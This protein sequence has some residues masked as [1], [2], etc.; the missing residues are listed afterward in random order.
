M[1]PRQPILLPGSLYSIPPRHELSHLIAGLRERDQG[2][3]RV[4]V[5]STTVRDDGIFVKR[6]EILGNGG[7]ERL[8]NALLVQERLRVLRCAGRSRGLGCGCVVSAP[9]PFCQDREPPNRRQGR[10][11]C[12]ISYRAV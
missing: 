7:A 8:I 10:I 2:L 1:L 3:L 4:D 5:D 11:R 9:P 12:C 6:D